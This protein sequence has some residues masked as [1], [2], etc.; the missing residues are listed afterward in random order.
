MQIL[1]SLPWKSA[2]SRSEHIVLIVDKNSSV[3]PIIDQIYE[4]YNIQLT[5]HNI[6]YRGKK[7]LP[8]SSFCL[9]SKNTKVFYFES[10]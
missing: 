9:F 6:R 4:R 5:I 3:Y 8:I 7:V 2:V 1:V 10:S